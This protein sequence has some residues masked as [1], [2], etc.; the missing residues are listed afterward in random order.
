MRSL[1]LGAVNAARFARRL[2]ASL[3]TLVLCGAVALAA[4]TLSAAGTQQADAT[5]R[6]GSGLRQIDV[7][8][9]DD[10]GE[11]AKRLT[12]A[13]LASL[14]GLPGVESV[15]PSLNASFTVEK[16]TGDGG[17]GFPV[18]LYANLV[19]P[20]V[21]P[22][23][24]AS[25]RERVFPLRPGE[26]VLPARADGE[27]LTGLLGRTVTAEYTRRTAEGQ[28][29]GVSARVR[30]VGI[31]DPAWQWDGPSAAHAAPGEV[32]AWAAARSGESPERFL[33]GEGYSGATVVATS[34]SQVG[35]V[36][37]ALTER[38]YF[39]VGVR[40]RVA[41]LPGVLGLFQWLSQG[42]LVLVTAVGVLAGLGIGG[43]VVR[44][45]TREVGVLRAVG[46]TRSEV[47]RAFSTE[48][49]LLALAAGVLASVL[50]TL[51]GGGSVLGLSTLEEFR[52]HLPGGWVSPP[53]WQSAA[54]VLLSVAAVLVGAMRPLR[55]AASLDP[56]AVLRDW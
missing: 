20:S 46:W 45:R 9:L 47:F 29:T 24:Q 31:S 25:V 41:E 3:I 1:T 49:G 13:A 53:L 17:E 33:A 35:P 6:T 40:D 52:Q 48:I 54:T 2:T 10:S 16:T 50:G 28:G 15:E 30:V 22:P 56:V 32:A 44:T 4:G 51:I 5:L 11:T 39:A 21:S 26:I 7:R 8:N 43:A 55:K 23:L 37:A 34:E 19:R 14:R 18:L 42:L 12:P 36:V 38:H 27:D